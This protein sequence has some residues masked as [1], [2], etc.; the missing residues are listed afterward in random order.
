MLKR[1]KLKDISKFPPFMLILFKPINSG[2]KFPTLACLFSMY[3][4]SKPS[5]SRN[6]P[7]PAKHLSMLNQVPHYTACTLL[8]NELCK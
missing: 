4:H 8:L 5:N 7:A 2:E 6:G 1:K 3:D